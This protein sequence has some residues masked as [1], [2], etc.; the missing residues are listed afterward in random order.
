MMQRWI[1][2]LIYGAAV[3]SS[4]C[5]RFDEPS[6]V[7]LTLSNSLLFLLNPEDYLFEIS[8]RGTFLNQYGRKWDLVIVD[9]LEELPVLAGQ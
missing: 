2:Y 5:G 1:L 7:L 4:V 8:N 3:K 6:N 9:G